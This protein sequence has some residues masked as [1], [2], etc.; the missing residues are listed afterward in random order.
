MFN[1]DMT[2]EMAAPKD[3]SSHNTIEAKTIVHFRMPTA[4]T[5]CNLNNVGYERRKMISDPKW[6]VGI[7]NHIRLLAEDQSIVEGTIHCIRSREQRWV[8]FEL[9]VQEAG[10]H[11]Y[12]LVPQI[13]AQFR[14]VEHVWYIFEYPWL[15]DTIPGP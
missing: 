12:V 15:S 3:H 8:E 6:A 11:H 4:G 9:D 14:L 2:S 7:G 1:H 10:L 5:D 13:W